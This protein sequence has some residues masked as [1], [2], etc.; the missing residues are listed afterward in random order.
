MLCAIFFC[1]FLVGLQGAYK[2]NFNQT[3]GLRTLKARGLDQ[4][5]SVR[6]EEFAFE[7]IEKRADLQRNSNLFCLKN[8]SLR[9]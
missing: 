3:T 5:C 1:I 9:Y 6:G 7:V 4:T 8:C 2:P